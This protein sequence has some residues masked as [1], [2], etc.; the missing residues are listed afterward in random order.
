[1]SAARNPWAPWMAW[2]EVAMSASEMMMASAQVVGQRGTRM[3]TARLPL[4]ARDQKEFTMMGVE[5]MQAAGESMLAMMSPM[6]V[7]G[8]AVAM[9]LSELMWGQMLRNGRQF[10]KWSPL[11]WSDPAAWGPPSAWS[12]APVEAGT[13]LLTEAVQQGNYLRATANDAAKAVSHVSRMA[14]KVAKRG[15]KPVKTRAKANA[16]RLARR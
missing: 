7:N 14:S 3:A 9:R 12:E 8:G 10:A 5:K 1:M 4:S 16:R 13:R 2:A 15:I 6:L 11:A